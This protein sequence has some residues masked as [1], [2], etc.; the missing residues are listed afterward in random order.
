MEIALRHANEIRPTLLNSPY[1]GPF[2][3]LRLWLSSLWLVA[4]SSLHLYLIHDKKPCLSSVI[5]IVEGKSSEIAEVAAAFE[6]IQQGAAVGSIRGRDDDDI[7]RTCTDTE[8][9]Q[10]LPRLESAVRVSKTSSD[11]TSDD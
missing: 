10:N 7:K 3:A 2:I 1:C 4:Q 11:P 9:S 8:R 5:A 6:K